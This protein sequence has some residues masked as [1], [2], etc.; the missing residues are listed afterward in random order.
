MTKRLRFTYIH[1]ER[2]KNSLSRTD[3]P[4]Q[5][6]GRAATSKSGLGT[7]RFVRRVAASACARKQSGFLC[8]SLRLADPA[9]RRAVDY[10]A[11][12][13]GLVQPE[14]DTF[15]GQVQLAAAIQRDP[16]ANA[17]IFILAGDANDSVA[18]REPDQ[19]L[20][21]P[22]PLPRAVDK[23]LGRPSGAVGA[24]GPDDSRLG[25]PDALLVTARR[26][27]EQ[28]DRKQERGQ[29]LR[30][31]RTSRVRNRPVMLVMGVKIVGGLLWAGLFGR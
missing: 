3:R 17:A 28:H 31:P 29:S 7:R 12:A 5:P 9:P 1:A 4:R 20:E 6:S 11:S 30:H 15:V 27:A 23:K 16:H 25:A 22:S 21:Q 18:L 14:G 24:D 8:S 13:Q 19:D 2:A 26:R 10:S